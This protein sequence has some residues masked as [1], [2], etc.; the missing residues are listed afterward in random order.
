MMRGFMNIHHTNWDTLLPM[1][2]FAIN[3]AKNRITRY[4]PHFL[5]Y[6]RQPRLPIEVPPINPTTVLQAEDEYVREIQ[7]NMESVYDYVRKNMMENIEQIEEKDEGK[8]E[9]L[10]EVPSSNAG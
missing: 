5:F 4:S 2:V 6:G 7:T 1:I 3:T 9:A 10:Y 8:Q